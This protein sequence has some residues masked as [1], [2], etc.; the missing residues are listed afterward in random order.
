MVTVRQALAEREARLAGICREGFLLAEHE[1][2]YWTNV[3]ARQG[4]ELVNAPDDVWTSIAW[5]WAAVLGDEPPKT[6]AL[7]TDV[8]DA[9]LSL[10]TWLAGEE[11][12]DALRS[13]VS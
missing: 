11:P 7:A 6:G 12:L 9:A 5:T 3:L 10:R 1:P 2:A 13:R 4:P 8:K